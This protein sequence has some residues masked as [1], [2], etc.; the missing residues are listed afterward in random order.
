MNYKSLLLMPCAAALVV[1][2]G[3]ASTATDLGPLEASV[4]KAQQTADEAKSMAADAKETAM[5][6]E[7]LAQQAIDSS[8]DAKSTAETALSEARDAKE[9]ADKM[10][11]KSMAK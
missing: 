3:C 9:M 4:A 7:K 6:A 5:R 1:L 2:G 11:K 10:F 8:R